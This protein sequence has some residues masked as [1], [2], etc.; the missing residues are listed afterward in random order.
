[1]QQA[2]DRAGGAA[3]NKGAEAA[4]AALRA[5]DAVAWLGSMDA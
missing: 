3:G 4:E 5:A 1:M 2:L